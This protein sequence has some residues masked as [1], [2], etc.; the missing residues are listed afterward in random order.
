MDYISHM[1]QVKEFLS[2]FRCKDDAELNYGG[3]RWNWRWYYDDY[4]NTVSEYLVL[5]DPLVF[6]KDLLHFYQCHRLVDTRENRVLESKGIFIDLN[7]FYDLT[8]A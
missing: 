5:E 3:N 6:N 1:A 7:L 8:K 4:G 2:M